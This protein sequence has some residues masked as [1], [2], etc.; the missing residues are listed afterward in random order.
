MLFLLILSCAD[1]PDDGRHEDPVADNDSTTE[2]TGDSRTHDSSGP[3]DQ[4]I[5]VD[6]DGDGLSEE[7]GDCNDADP[8]AYV[9]ATEV[10]DGDDEDCD[11]VIDEFTG[12]LYYPDEDGD[13]CY[14]RDAEVVVCEG[15]SPPA[16]WLPIGLPFDCDDTDPTVCSC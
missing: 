3:N 12:A 8:T 10:C 7:R 15:D 5:S 14:S 2:D 13:D 9:G 1:A 6:D 11:G 16:G 4:G